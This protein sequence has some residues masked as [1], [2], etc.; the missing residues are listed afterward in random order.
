MTVH[1]SAYKLS[2]LVPLCESTDGGTLSY[3]NERINC[4][5]CRSIAGLGE[6]PQPPQFILLDEATTCEWFARCGNETSIVAHH[7]V[8]TYVPIC[9]RCAIYLGMELPT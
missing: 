5:Q 9:T 3:E 2:E 1:H 4:L 8:L 7:P 6:Q